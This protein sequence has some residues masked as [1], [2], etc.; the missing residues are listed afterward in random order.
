[1]VV[2]GFFFEFCQIV[3]VIYVILDVSL[4]FVKIFPNK[5]FGPFFWAGNNLGNMDILIL[6]L[7]PLL[8]TPPNFARI[9]HHQQAFSSPSVKAQGCTYHPVMAMLGIS[10]PQ[11]RLYSKLSMVL[12]KDQ[13]YNTLL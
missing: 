8:Y 12:F 10:A 13:P 6:L 9:R 5:H 2:L 3:S 4:D 7:V 1:M 11:P